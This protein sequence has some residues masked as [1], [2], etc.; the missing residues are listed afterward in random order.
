MEQDRI[1]VLLTRTVC[2]SL[3]CVAPV[4]VSPSGMSRGKLSARLKSNRIKISLQ[5]PMMA[6]VY[7]A[8]ESLMNSSPYVTLETYLQMPVIYATFTPHTNIFMVGHSFAWD[9]ARCFMMTST[10]K[11]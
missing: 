5:K 8:P 9:K 6:F 7:V 11:R 10:S 4:T 1:S 2:A 3:G